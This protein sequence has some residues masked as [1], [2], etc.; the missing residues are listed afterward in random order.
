MIF[1]QVNQ[2]GPMR[3]PMNLT[4]EQFRE[5]GVHVYQIVSECVNP[6]EGISFL[7]L[8]L[9]SIAFAHFHEKDK[10][11]EALIDSIKISMKAFQQ[12]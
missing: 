2:R 6:T 4:D 11:E 10:V 3:V 7:S 9:T 12:E 1:C 5:K 8:V